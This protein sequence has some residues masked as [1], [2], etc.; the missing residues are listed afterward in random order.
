MMID[1][2]VDKDLEWWE[3]RFEEGITTYKEYLKEREDGI[4]LIECS[5]G[6]YP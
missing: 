5:E 4:S 3:W 6:M 2:M 1:V